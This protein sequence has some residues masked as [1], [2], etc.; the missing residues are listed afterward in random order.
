[1]NTTFDFTTASVK[2]LRQH[3]ITVLDAKNIQ[4]MPQRVI[5]LL[6]EIA[7]AE[8]FNS[9]ISRKRGS[10]ARQSLNVFVNGLKEKE[11]KALAEHIHETMLENEALENKA[12]I[13]AS[14]IRRMALLRENFARREKELTESITKSLGKIPLE[15]R[16]TFNEYVM[17]AQD[18]AAR[19]VDNDEDLNDNE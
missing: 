6:D 13:H 2:E 17:L 7:S 4:K 19:R 14:K 5:T 3:V 16:P 11:F 10:K 15:Q 1:M 12:L 8:A 9:D 18:A